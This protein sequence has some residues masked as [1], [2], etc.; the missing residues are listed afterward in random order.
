VY[1]GPEITVQVT[2][3]RA[4][5]ILSRGSLI[6]NTSITAKPS[7]LG[8]FPGGGGIARDPGGGGDLLLSPPYNVNGPGSASYRYYLFTITTS[9][10]DVDDVQRIC[11]SADE[12]Q[13][14]RGC[15]HVSHGN[16]STECIPHDAPPS[17][18]QDMIKAGLNAEPGLGE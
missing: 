4:L 10:D 12:G 7:T 14:L 8:G 5:A 15:F 9:A 2:G 11:T 18:V 13:T 1:I 16:F 6:L 3:Q 17:T